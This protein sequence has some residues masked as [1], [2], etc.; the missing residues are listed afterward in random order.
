MKQSLPALGLVLAL[1]MTAATAVRAD[2]LQDIK[3]RKSLV[4]GTFG[5]IAPF[6]FPD[7]KTR[8]T[9]GFDVDLC[10]AIAKEMGVEA[11]VKGFPVGVHI[12]ELK[13][14][15]IDIII[16]NLGYTKTRAEQIDFS[17]AY[18]VLTEVVSVTKQSGMTK[19]DELA[20]KKISATKG[21]TSEQA[22]RIKLPT[23]TPM[24]FQ[25]ASSAYLALQQGKV[26]G[27][28][29]NNVSAASFALQSATTPKPVVVLAEHTYLQ[30]IGVGMKKGE[31]ALHQ[32]VNR[33]LASLEKTGFLDANWDK[34]I[35]TGSDLKLKRTYK[36]TPISAIDFQPLN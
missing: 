32:E 13:L 3:A 25:D 34:W 16:S 19:L 29:I 12:P 27:F 31:T 33:I 6:G 8:E 18:N 22:V 15:H 21:S 10:K 24:T 23:A 30:P 1:G 17:D 5:A 7:P 20:G 28:A 9:V 36:V 14:G 11:T 4:C 35:G 26:D 2:Q